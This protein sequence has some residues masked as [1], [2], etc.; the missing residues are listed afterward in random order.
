MY[1]KAHLL[2]TKDVQG[3]D[4]IS[5]DSTVGLI[6]EVCQISDTALWIA[7]STPKFLITEINVLFDFAENK[8][9]PQKMM[10]CE[11]VWLFQPR[12]RSIV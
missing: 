12:Y 4:P 8:S 1:Q 3:S 9:K 10:Q 11:M 2:L 6:Y 7:P 5:D